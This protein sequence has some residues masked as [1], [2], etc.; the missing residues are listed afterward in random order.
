M[1]T[2]KNQ[3][4]GNSRVSMKERPKAQ[5]AF[6]FASL[7]GR[8]VTAHL[9]G[10]K[11]FSGLFHACTMEKDY[12]IALKFVQE[13]PSDP[14]GV[15]GDIL[16]CLLIPGRELMM[17]KAEN[18]PINGIETDESEDTKVFQTDGE[19][20]KG[21][22]RMTGQELSALDGRELTMWEGGGDEA[23]SGLENMTLNAASGS[24]NDTSWDQFAVNE[25]QFGVKSTYREDL[26]TTKLDMSKISSQQREAAERIAKEI[27]AGGT[28]YQEEDAAGDDEEAIHSAVLGTGGYE[29]RTTVQQNQRKG[30]GSHSAWEERGFDQVVNGG[31][32][33]G[34]AQEGDGANLGENAQG[35]AL[36]APWTKSINALNLESTM[37]V[38]RKERKPLPNLAP[39]AASVRLTPMPPP[40]K[41][42]KVEKEPTPVS[43]LNPA[44]KAF[45]PGKAAGVLHLAVSPGGSLSG[46]VQQG[47]HDRGNFM[48][49][50]QNQGGHQGEHFQPAHRGQ[51][52]QRQEAKVKRSF[53]PKQLADQR[54]MQQLCT[55]L[56]ERVCK[57]PLHEKDGTAW[58]E[59]NG[60]PIQQ[61]FGVPSITQEQ[62]NQWLLRHANRSQGGAPQNHQQQYNQQ[63]Y[64]GGPVQQ[65]FGGQQQQYGQNFGHMQGMPM[66]GNEH[67]PQGEHPHM[68]YPQ[69]EANMR[70]PQMMDGMQGQMGMQQQPPPQQRGQPMPPQQHQ[71]PP[72]QPM[73]QQGPGPQHQ[74][75]PQQPQQHPGQPNVMMMGQSGMGM[76]PQGGMPQGMGM[77]MQGMQMQGQPPQ[78]HQQQGGQQQMHPGM[79]MQQGGPGMAPM[80]SQMGNPSPQPPQPPH[81]GPGQHMQQPAG[82]PQQNLGQGPPM[83][84]HGQ[85][86]QGPAQGQHMM[87]QGQGQQ[88]P[89]AHQQ[90]MMQQQG[91]YAMMPGQMPNSQGMQMQQ[92]MPQNVQGMQ[93]MQG[94][95]GNMQGMQGNQY[96]VIFVNPQQMQ[97]APYQQQGWMMDPSM[98]QMQGMNG[99]GGGFQ[100][101]QQHGH[102]QWS[103]QP[104]QTPNQGQGQ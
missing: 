66:Q 24:H 85:G 52:Q 29:H 88:G 79:S 53:S 78:G 70:H 35:T 100:P 87:P 42:P 84:P 103:Q 23:D 92:G 73:H 51:Q 20:R 2:A 76:M 49:G 99:Q 48:G 72:P 16:P 93:N 94:M 11:V 90:G 56:V 91:M 47:E 62:L 34:G 101:G 6:M 61:I 32:G 83:G 77:Q 54:T 63:M 38:P 3:Q 28:A 36:L 58:P 74:M 15:T 67:G 57:E 44:A 7:Y 37:A 50:Y 95:Q 81:P 55:E 21:K 97:A 40:P 68:G 18:I 59:A 4:S 82:P 8:S 22:G 64:M 31:D 13:I 39:K 75:P 86:P 45:Q 104:N 43:T 19:I 10:G 30:K 17:L 96:P 26:Y 1:N 60:V 69:Q 65:N 14:E 12:S 89:G 25:K 80:P 71:Q 46:S 102:Q 41:T 98:Q 27:E 5:T 33:K 9:R